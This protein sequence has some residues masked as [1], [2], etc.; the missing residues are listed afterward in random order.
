MN[1]SSTASPL[2]VYSAAEEKYCAG[3]LDAFR[4]AHPHIDVRF[5]FGI[6]VALQRR[7][8]AALESGTPDAD[9]VWSSAM[10][11]QLGLVHAG[12]ARTYRSPQ[13]DDLP[14]GSVFRD[15]A[16]ATTLEPLATVVNMR[17]IDREQPIGS[18]GEI[19]RA[20]RDND[21]LRD[22]LACFD[23]EHNGLGFLAL[24]YESLHLP[25]FDAFMAMLAEFGARKCVSN[26]DMVTE[27]ESGRAA[28]G[29]HLLDSYAR[30]A[31]QANV[32]L[33]IARSSLA[34]LAI[35]RIAFIPQSAPHPEAAQCFLDFMLSREG[36]RQLAQG[37]FR[38]LRADPH[39]EA[40][41]LR[42]IRID[43]GLAEIIEPGRRHA[44]LERWQRCFA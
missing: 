10:D 36:Q 42:P 9:I 39:C 26:P 2:V 3:L 5:E 29:F 16:Y 30:R 28:I 7:Y 6:S 4:A 40:P 12:H 14:A 24:M 33:A 15:C 11:L 38:P 18:L 35:S 25:E 19:T 8:L 44:F 41:A 31:V 17:H 34:P 13:A 27:L 21:R 37:G 1:R 22:K 32:E 23:I 20:M 43:D